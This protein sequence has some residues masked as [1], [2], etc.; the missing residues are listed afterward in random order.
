MAL[1]LGIHQTRRGNWLPATV[2]SE[3]PPRLLSPDS[4]FHQRL[5]RSP[6]TLR[7]PSGTRRYP[8]WVEITQKGGCMQWS[9]Q[10]LTVMGVTWDNPAPFRPPHLWLH[11]TPRCPRETHRRGEPTVW[12]VGLWQEVAFY[13]TTSQSHLPDINRWLWHRALYFWGGEFGSPLHTGDQ[14]LNKGQRSGS[15]HGSCLHAEKGDICKSQSRVK[16]NR[17]CRDLGILKFQ[18]EETREHKLL[19]RTV[20]HDF[21]HYWEGKTARQGQVSVRTSL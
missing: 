10:Q 6:G 1:L 3:W 17:N 15:C 12:P 11:V 20:F 7:P 2:R 19:E 21:Q 4:H 8:T 16:R 9:A 14:Y 5:L 18:Q 13:V